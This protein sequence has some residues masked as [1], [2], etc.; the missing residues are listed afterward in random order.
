VVTFLAVLELLKR[1]MVTVRQESRFGDIE[2][3]YIEGSGSLAD[4]GPVDEYGEV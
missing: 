4:S 3:E 1:N 2:I